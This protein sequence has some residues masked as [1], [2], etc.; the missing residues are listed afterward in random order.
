MEILRVRR[1]HPDVPPEKYTQVDERFRNFINCN[2]GTYGSSAQPASRSAASRSLTIWYPRPTTFWFLL[3]HVST[4]LPVASKIAL[5][6]FRALV[7]TASTVQYAQRRRSYL[8][9]YTYTFT[10]SAPIH[11][12]PPFRPVRHLRRA[13]H[14]GDTGLPTCTPRTAAAAPHVRHAHSYAYITRQLWH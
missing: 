1:E 4:R 13:G 6:G 5:L 3:V 14:P 11:F 7:A 2:L 8:T 9:G 10:W 12:I